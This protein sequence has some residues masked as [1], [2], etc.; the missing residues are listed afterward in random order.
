MSKPKLIIH[1]TEPADEVTPMNKAN[2]TRPMMNMVVMLIIMKI[3]TM[4]KII[5]FDSPH[6]LHHME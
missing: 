3:A 1:L 6:V 2:Q 4:M 5:V